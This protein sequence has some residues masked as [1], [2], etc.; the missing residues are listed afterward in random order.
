MKIE[1]KGHSGCQID[2]VAEEGNLYVYK[3]TADTKYLN[4]LALQ[5]QKQKAAAAVPHQ[6]IRVPQVYD[7]E[8]DDKTVVVKMQYVYSKNFV[9][10]FNHAGFEQV[11]YLIGALKYFIEYEVGQCE[12]KSVPAT[13][14]QEKFAEVRS[15]VVTNPLYEGDSVVQTII[16]RAAQVF[17]ALTEECVEFHED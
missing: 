10:F 8:R 4:R 6:H 17:G 15:K 3:S 2:V 14:F 1:V 16:D 5:A 12:M 7:I 9:E 13:V 11:D